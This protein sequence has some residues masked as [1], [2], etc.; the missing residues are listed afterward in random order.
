L[1]TQAQ[2]TFSTSALSRPNHAITAVYAG[3]N[4]FQ[5]STSIVY[6]ET[7][8][9]GASATTLS[10]APNPSAF[11]QFTTFTAIVRA[12]APGAG[13]LTGSVSFKEG[14]TVLGN[15][16]L[17]EVAG[18]DRAT[19]AFKSLTAGSHTITAVYGGDNNFLASSDDDSA[20][21][22]VVNPDGTTTGIRSNVNP[23]VVGTTVTFTATL[24]ASAPGSGI[25][26]GTVTFKDFGNT[27]GTGSL[28]GAGVATFTTS[29]LT[30]G[31]H[32]ITAVYGGDTN[33][34]PS[35][36]IAFGQTVKTSAALAATLPWPSLSPTT[37]A[38]SLQ[39]RAT[40]ALRDLGVLA[41]GLTRSHMDHF[42]AATRGP[43]KLKAIVSDDDWLARQFHDLGSRHTPSLSP[44]GGVRHQGCKG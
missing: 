42:F 1:N 5:G 8:N 6:G 12:A 22:Q 24:H 28:D 7:V 27:L 13:T 19:F 14:T 36:S 43:L 26:T 11:G 34:S 44:T 37:A 39:A 2:A 20:A 16:T 41:P 30:V 29:S 17:Q 10:S 38:G 21:P 40:S 18:L 3:D 15:G 4:S 25:P 9:K 33:F 23:S 32:A 31:N 35:T